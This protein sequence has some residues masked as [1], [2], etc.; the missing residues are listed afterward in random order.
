MIHAIVGCSNSSSSYVSV[1]DICGIV[2][3]KIVCT[4]LENFVF[5]SVQL[6]IRTIYL[7]YKYNLS[8]YKHKVQIILSNS[9]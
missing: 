2:K 7:K 1:W 4:M 3:L 9:T 5:L 6:A 8:L